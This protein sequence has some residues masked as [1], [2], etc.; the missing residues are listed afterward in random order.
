MITAKKAQPSF[1][2][3]PGDDRADCFKD[4]QHV[5]PQ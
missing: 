2:T 3:V 1:G 5:Q 4:N